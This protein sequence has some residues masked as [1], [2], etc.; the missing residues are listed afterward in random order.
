MFV[1]SKP[2][3]GCSISITNRWTCWNSFDV[4]KMMFEFIRC[5][6]KCCLTSSTTFMYFFC[7]SGQRSPPTSQPFRRTF[8]PWRGWT[9][10]CLLNINARRK[11]RSNRDSHLWQWTTVNGS[12][13]KDWDESQKLE[14]FCC[15]R[16]FKCWPFERGGLWHTPGVHAIQKFPV[17]GQSQLG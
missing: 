5:L 1:N 10:R 15:F 6:I 14:R 11:S 9:W 12:I 17:G 16:R 2:K 4:W 3:I 8:W 13:F 7:I